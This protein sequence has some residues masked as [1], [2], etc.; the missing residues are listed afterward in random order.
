[1]SRY[2]AADALKQQIE[3]PYT[4]YPVMIQIRKAIKE[5]IDS[6][7]S[8]DIVFCRECKYKDTELC[9]MYKLVVAG[10]RKYDDFCS[11]GERSEL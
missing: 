2:I 10:V 9:T 4:E 11:Y 1:M 6:A 5:F 8:I 3:S 7:P